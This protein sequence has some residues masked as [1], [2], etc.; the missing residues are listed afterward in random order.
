MKTK[1]YKTKSKNLK[2]I[3]FDFLC[4]HN[5][6]CK[7]TLAILL[8]LSYPYLFPQCDF[9]GLSESVSCLRS[10]LI[11]YTCLLFL[12]LYLGTK[13]VKISLWLTVFVLL[14]ISLYAYMRKTNENYED[15]PDKSAESDYKPAGAGEDPGVIPPI[16]T[17]DKNNLEISETDI[18]VLLNKDLNT[19][20]I[21]EEKKKKLYEEAGGGLEGLSHLLKK[22]KEES[23]YEND[24]KNTDDYT[25]AQA[26]RETHRLIDTV[27]QLKETMAEMMPLMHTGNRVMELY[28]KMGGTGLIKNQ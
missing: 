9:P 19:E 16:Q 28:S 13:S 12:F 26:Q 14:C 8:L 22:A 17:T 10:K 3:T 23:P 6:N 27:K 18:E 21:A 24:N 5:H 4:R 7:I 2:K 15:S 25:P 1:Q 20:Q 11:R